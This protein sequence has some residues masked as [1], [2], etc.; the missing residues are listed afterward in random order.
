LLFCH[1]CSPLLFAMA[2]CQFAIND[3]QCFA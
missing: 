3:C 1:S 2:I